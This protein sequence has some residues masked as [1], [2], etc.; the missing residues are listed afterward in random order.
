MM[1]HIHQFLQDLSYALVPP[2]VVLIL[3][4]CRIIVLPTRGELD[5]LAHFLGGLSIAWMTII[6]WQRWTSHGW[7]AKKIPTWLRDY[8]VWGTVGLIGVAWEFMETVLTHYVGVRMQFSIPET[9][10]DLFM[11]LSGGIVFLIFYRIFGRKR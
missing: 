11:D 9:M 1:K 2:L 8:T 7:I 3:F 5:I 4:A 6:L 10:G